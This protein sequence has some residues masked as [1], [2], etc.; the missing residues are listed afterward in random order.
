VALL[1]YSDSVA[2]LVDSVGPTESRR[3]RTA[4]TPETRAR[5][6]F[7]LG[8]TAVT[9]GQVAGTEAGTAKSCDLA[10]VADEALITAM[11]ALPGGAAFNQA[12]TLT[13]LQSIP[14]FQTYVTQ[15]KAQ[16]CK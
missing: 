5:V 2:A 10:K 7:I 16:V 11:I 13:L 1:Q 12:N 4:A 8:A 9:L 14:E 15:L 6:K 3:R